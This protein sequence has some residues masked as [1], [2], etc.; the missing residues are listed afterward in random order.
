MK[1]YKKRFFTLIEVMIS[2][3][4][5]SIIIMFLFNYFVKITKIEKKIDI[6]R[7]ETFDKS[8]LHVRL[9]YIFTQIKRDN[10]FNKSSIYLENE[11]F[12]ILFTIFDAGI[13]PDPNF[14]GF[15]QGR[16]YVDKAKNLCLE[17]LSNDEKNKRKEILFKNIKS[18]EYKFLSK[19]DEKL[20]KFIKDDITK[21]IFWYNSWPKDFSEMPSI[22]HMTINKDLKYVFF[23][24]NN[25]IN[26]LY[27]KGD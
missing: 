3:S 22:V 21:N 27:G 25:S 9:N 23:I 6:I 5:L 11:K 18:L 17:K 20:K 2:I 7:N 15:I 26:V 13:D 8:L 4:L 16:L 19:K 24:P 1:Y 12:P 10:F 14:S